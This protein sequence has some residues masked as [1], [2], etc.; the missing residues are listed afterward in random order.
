MRLLLLLALLA[1]V[2]ARAQEASAQD[3]VTPE[4]VLASTWAEALGGAEAVAWAL[5]DAAA[6]ST[7]AGPEEDGD[8][9]RA[10]RT[11]ALGA[12][13]TSATLAAAVQFSLALAD[14]PERAS[15]D[16]ALTDDA[17]ALH[18][19]LV[20]VAETASGE[21]AGEPGAP[22][23]WAERAAQVRALAA[24]LGGAV[25]ALGLSAE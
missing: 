21:D 3:D 15:V 13:G 23:A 5:E 4:S 7:L 8:A 2:P 1:T 25:G 16:A 12:A 9:D 22:P 6:D 18:G 20:W 17:V 14:A 10:L 19:L 24:R 11:A